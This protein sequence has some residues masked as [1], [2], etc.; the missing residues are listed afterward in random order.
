LATSIAPSPLTFLVPH[1]CHH[2]ASAGSPYGSVRLLRR[3]PYQRNGL[4]PLAVRTGSRD[5]VAQSDNLTHRRVAAQ[6]QRTR[7][8][9]AWTG[10][11][12]WHCIAFTEQGWQHHGA[13]IGSNCFSCHS[14][15]PRHYARRS[16]RAW[17]QPL[18]SRV[19]GAR[20]SCAAR[21]RAGGSAVGAAVQHACARTTHGCGGTRMASIALVSAV[22]K[23]GGRQSG[24]MIDGG[25]R[26]IS[27]R[28][29]MREN[30]AI[31]DIKARKKHRASTRRQKKN[32]SR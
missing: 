32:C 29:G 22:S 1:R 16:S 5:A 14:R 12:G 13:Q 27:K 31:S 20:A 10:V 28:A 8:A 4:A 26:G 6:H 17:R 15:E 2:N 30:Q 11:N 7:P 25:D 23:N 19:A 24:R 3:A 18:T 21:R 9:R